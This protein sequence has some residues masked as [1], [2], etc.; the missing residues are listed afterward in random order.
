MRSERSPQQS[1]G[2]GQRD[3]PATEVPGGTRRWGRRR[4]GRTCSLS[5]SLHRPHPSLH[6]PAPLTF[7]I[8]RR[9][10]GRLPGSLPSAHQSSATG[11]RRARRLLRKEQDQRG[12]PDRSGPRPRASPPLPRRPA[13]PPRTCGKVN[14]TC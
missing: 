10:Q 3:A 11:S 4:R 8:L 7:R 5:R 13:E 6:P 1:A 12:V 9:R 2:Q 14:G